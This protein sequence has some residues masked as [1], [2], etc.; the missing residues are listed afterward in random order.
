[1]AATAARNSGYPYPA[2]YKRRT[3]PTPFRLFSSMPQPRN[4]LPTEMTEV[5]SSSTVLSAAGFSTKHTMLLVALLLFRCAKLGFSKMSRTTSSLFIHPSS[6]RDASCLLNLPRG[7]SSTSK[8]PK[9]KPQQQAILWSGGVYQED[10]DALVLSCL[11]DPDINIKAVPDWLEKQIYRSTIT[12]VLTSLHKALHGLHGKRLLQ[13]YEFQITRL[14]RRQKNLRKAMSTM[15]SHYAQKVEYSQKH[16]EKLES[17]ADRLLANK[18]INQPLIPD[19]IERQLYANCLKI[20]FRVLDLLAVSFRVTLCGHDL[21]VLLEPS[22]DDVT[23][24]SMQ[25][26]ALERLASSS[27]RSTTGSTSCMND[28]SVEK[29]MQVARDLGAHSDD[30]RPFFKRWLNPANNDFIA[31][32]HASVYCL[33]LGIVDDLLE[34]TE[35]QLLSDRIEFDLVPLVEDNVNEEIDIDLTKEAVAAGIEKDPMPMVLKAHTVSVTSSKTANTKSVALMVAG[36]AIG[37]ALHSV[38]EHHGNLDVSRILQSVQHW[39]TTTKSSFTSSVQG[40]PAATS[41]CV[42]AALNKVRTLLNQSPGGQNAC[43]DSPSDVSAVKKGWFSTFRT[44]PSN[45]SE[46]EESGSD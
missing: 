37:Y 45:D 21:K 23:R 36:V 2:F 43:A 32:L 3:E 14:P 41:N 15:S 5:A 10:I 7:G 16:R 31:Q 20:V 39:A 40:L 17:V 25:E 8:E 1:M 12:L 46:I 30:Q 28:L 24:E 9:K 6:S 33:V 42:S 13:H 35:I 4:G 18:N 29:M 19:A 34:H 27:E 26:Q 38:V 11:N 44:K 22:D